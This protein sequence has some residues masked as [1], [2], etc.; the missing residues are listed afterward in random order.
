[1]MKKDAMSEDEFIAEAQVMKYVI[2]TVVLL[3]SVGH[4]KRSALLS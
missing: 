4:A 3:S 1:M 2:P